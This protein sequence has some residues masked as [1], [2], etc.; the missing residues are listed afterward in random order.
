MSY[1]GFYK[2]S[3]TK[4]IMKTHYYLYNVTTYVI[5]LICVYYIPLIIKL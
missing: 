1:L 4:A 5:H 2:G 3:F